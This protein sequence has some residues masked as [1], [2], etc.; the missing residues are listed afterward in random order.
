MHP[1]ALPPRRRSTSIWTRRRAARPPGRGSTQKRTSAHV[2]SCRTPSGRNNN[3][4]VPPC[5]AATCNRRNTNG[6]SFSS[7][8]ST[9]ATAR[10]RSDCS[11]A[12]RCSAGLLGCTTRRASGGIPLWKTAGGKRFRSGSN[13]ITIPPSLQACR[14]TCSAKVCR[15]VPS[16]SASH[17][18]RLPRRSPPPGRRASQGGH[19]VETTPSP[20]EF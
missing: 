1:P 5:S 10:Q 11:K 8:A 6:S 17:S 12:Q 13:T 15:P 18:T 20:S 2:G 14:A 3:P 16:P 9:A 4:R 7:P 19:P